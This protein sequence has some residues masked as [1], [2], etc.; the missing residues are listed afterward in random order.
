M[1]VEKTLHETNHLQHICGIS[2]VDNDFERLK[3]YNISEL[4]E[5]SPK[6][7]QQQQQQEDVVK[8]EAEITAAT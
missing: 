2:V 3:R 7:Q 6:E 4:Y 8:H 5:P 1:A